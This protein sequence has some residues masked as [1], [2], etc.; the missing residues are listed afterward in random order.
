MRN[1]HQNVMG[2]PAFESGVPAM[3]M[4]IRHPRTRRVGLNAEGVEC[5]STTAKKCH[6]SKALATKVLQGV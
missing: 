4:A 2:T 1:L 3:P 5:L 6:V